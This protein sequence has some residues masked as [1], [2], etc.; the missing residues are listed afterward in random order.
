MNKS[1][2]DR[3]ND[4]FFKIS[5]LCA[6]ICMQEHDLLT[7]EG[8]RVAT[9]GRGMSADRKRAKADQFNILHQ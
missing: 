1:P 5:I 8:K 2:S 6:L 7:P 3:A 4:L 9:R